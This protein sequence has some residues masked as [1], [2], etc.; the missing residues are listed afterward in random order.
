MYILP[1]YTE[2]YSEN[3]IEHSSDK[4]D[5]QVCNGIGKVLVAVHDFGTKHPVAKRL[6]EFLSYLGILYPPEKKDK[7][8]NNDNN[9]NKRDNFVM[10]DVFVFGG[11]SRDQKVTMEKQ[12][13]IFEDMITNFK[14]KMDDCVLIACHPFKNEEE[15]PILTQKLKKD[16]VMGSYIV[17]LAWESN[18]NFARDTILQIG[19]RV[20]NALK[21]YGEKLNHKESNANI[22]T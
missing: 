12:V 3:Y 4:I 17:I 2:R 11:Q 9:D 20:K 16:G 18:E 21:L 5:M 15:V 7:N 22:K 14:L 13:E 19:L 1:R 8:D 6:R 10:V